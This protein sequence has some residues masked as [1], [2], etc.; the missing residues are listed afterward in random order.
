MKIAVLSDIHGN[1]PALTE[2]IDHI[3]R[4]QADRVYVAGDIVNRGPR[5]QDCLLAL[6]EA[7]QNY[8]WQMIRG[9]HED[10]VIER[11]DHNDPKIGPQYELYK[12]VHF[13][14]NQL[15]CDISKLKSLPEIIREFPSFDCEVRVV[16]ASMRNN[17]DGIYSETTDVELREQIAP[18]PKVFLTGHT[19]RPLVR[20]LNGTLV[21]N[22]GSCGLPF[23]GDTRTGYAQVTQHKGQW[24]AEIIRLD[25]DIHQAEKDFYDTGYLEG[26]GPLSALVLLELKSA[27]SQL[28]QW[29]TRYAKPVFDGVMSV[30]EA[31]EEF[32]SEPITKL[33]W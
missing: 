21:V 19:H 1:F 32:L 25:Y 5:S 29:S 10:Y 6:E 12:P 14:F 2:V 17:R 4:W 9:N 11:A 26:A 3:Q 15:N 30:S 7:Q 18:P 28:Y 16:H 8:G 23:D 31:T 27:I 22:A 24:Q 20:M 13:T 33:Y